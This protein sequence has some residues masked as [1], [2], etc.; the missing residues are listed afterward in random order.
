MILMVIPQ[1]SVNTPWRIYG[2]NTNLMGLFGKDGGRGIFGRK[3][4]STCNLN[5]LNLLLLFFF[6]SVKFVFWHISRRSRYEICSKLTI[7]TPEHVKLTI[8][9]TTKT[10]LTLF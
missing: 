3:N 6:S 9:L 1:N 10:S 5:L 4:T 7:K 8:K 2:Q